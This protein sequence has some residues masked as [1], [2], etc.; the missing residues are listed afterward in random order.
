L[1]DAP[2]FERFFFVASEKAFSTEKVIQAAEDLAEKSDD[3]KSQ[4]LRLPRGL[5]QSSILLL[6]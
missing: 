4:N 5:E 6:K 2:E 1:D 3:A